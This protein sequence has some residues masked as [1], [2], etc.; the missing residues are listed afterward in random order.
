MSEEAGRLLG[1]IRRNDTSRLAE[2]IARLAGIFQ[3]R[4][5]ATGLDAEAVID[6]VVLRHGCPRRRVYLQERHAAQAF[7]EALFQRIPRDV[8]P[9]RLEEILG[10]APKAGPDD[11]V[12]VQ[13]E[14]RTHL[15][16][17]G[18]PA[19]VAEKFL[20]FEQAYRLILELGG[21][22]CYP[23]LA[24][25]AKPIC[26][27]ED[28]VDKLI[29]SIRTNNIHCAE[30]IPIRNEPAV[31]TRYVRAMRD[32]GLA[33]TAGTEHNTLSLLAIEPTCV[34]G[35]P[36][37]RELKAIFWEGAC[38][39]AAHQFLSLHGE[40]GFVDGLGRPNPAFGDAAGRIEAFARLGAA[41]IQRYYEAHPP[42]K[43]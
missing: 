35:A 36:I 11:A 30:F 9:G 27:Y 22:P 16:K 25:G 3:S 38:V 37:P 33:V 32:A 20:T 2:M 29:E 12:A 7:Q 4:G 43:A 14:I 6:M 24:D 26:P 8:R 28:P 34:G 40:C 5:L 18:K 19:F 13:N 15:M 17:A 1:I 21:I 10:A 41:V 23:T 31:L 39:V 42:P